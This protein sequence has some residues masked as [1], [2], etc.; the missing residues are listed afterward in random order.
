M[1]DNINKIKTKIDKLQDELSA[2]KNLFDVFGF[3][4][5]E[6]NLITY[7]GKQNPGFYVKYEVE[8]KEDISNI[9]KFFEND[10][11]KTYI[12]RDGSFSSL[13]TDYHKEKPG[14]KLEISKFILKRTETDWSVEWF[15]KKENNDLLI[16]VSVEPK[17]TAP[18]K[19]IFALSR[20]DYPKDA[21]GFRTGPEYLVTWLAGGIQHEYQKINYGYE[22]VYSWLPEE[23]I[24]SVLGLNKSE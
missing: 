4:A 2:T 19:N 15:T 14:K 22:H 3:D 23:D 20:K 7:F 24:W 11:L 17:F 6:P 21:R 9:V 10:M 5:F 12:F 8:T 16:R 13:V 1:T 18:I